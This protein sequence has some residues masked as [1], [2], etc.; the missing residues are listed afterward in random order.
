[1]TSVERNDKAEQGDGVKKG[2][3]IFKLNSTAYYKG[4]NY[5][6]ASLVSTYLRIHYDINLVFKCMQ[7]LLKYLLLFLSNS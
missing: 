3:E 4:H 5:V 2:E 1:M 6:I 7:L